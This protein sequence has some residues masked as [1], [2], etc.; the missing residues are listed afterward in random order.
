MAIDTTRQLIEQIRNAS[1]IGENTATRVGNA[2]NSILDDV[3]NANDVINKLAIDGKPLTL[4]S[5]IRDKYPRS[6]GVLT[7]LSTVHTYVYD[8]SGVEF[9]RLTWDAANTNVNYAVFFGND[10]TF[11]TVDSYI[12]PY[13]ITAGTTIIQ[14]PSGAAYVAF[15]LGS[16][17]QVDNSYNFDKV[18]DA[19][20]GIQDGFADYTQLTFLQTQ[21]GFLKNNGVLD[22]TSGTSWKVYLYSVSE[23]DKFYIQ[24]PNL[25]A[26]YAFYG[27]FSSS[28]LSGS[29]LMHVPSNDGLKHLVTVPPGAAVLVINAG[30]SPNWGTTAPKNIQMLGTPKMV[31]TEDVED[32]VSG[33]KNLPTAGTITD[34]MDSRIDKPTI[35]VYNYNRS[36]LLDKN[37]LIFADYPTQFYGLSSSPKGVTLNDIKSGDDFKSYGA[38]NFM[39]LDL[40]SQRSIFYIYKTCFADRPFATSGKMRISFNYKSLSGAKDF[41]VFL[42]VWGASP[43]N[44]ASG[45]IAAS[46]S[47]VGTFDYTFTVP[48]ANISSISY[49][50]VYLFKWGSPSAIDI[51]I[52]NL[53]ITDDIFDAAPVQRFSGDYLTAFMH[54]NNYIGK[55]CLYIGDSIS[56]ENNYGW[57]QMIETTYQLC[58]VR[59]MPGQLAPA[60]GGITVRPL[61]ADESSLANSAKSIWYR[62][63]GARMN[64][65]SFD[66]ISLFGGTND[67]N[68]YTT[69]GETTD[70]PYVDDASTFGTPAD[71]TDTWT[72]AL[73]FAQC[74]MGCVEMLRRDFPNNEIILATPYPMSY[75]TATD[76]DTN[77]PKSET[78]AQMIVKIG[79]KYGLKVVP[80]YW[81]IFTQSVCRAFTRD[82]VHPNDVLAR[83][84][85]IKYA[86]VL[87]Y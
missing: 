56:T 58:W 24:Q 63:A 79:Y 66:I 46:D 64:I 28:T 65:Y 12:K 48:T 15:S 72:N 85:A 76:P 42:Y 29:K 50:E 84:M 21:Y 20:N 10:A 13:T 7:N 33:N 22:G 38:L 70:K 59:G 6:T 75:G 80:L 61:Q 27:F 68:S 74:L 14:V 43:N 35:E 26:A 18:V 44:Y 54:P 32:F 8:L 19:V 31:V 60:N 23:G 1:Q 81:G 83:Q 34:Y 82:G 11:A 39:Q 2:M 73:T 67:L 41:K 86:Q 40:L 62:C 47:K 57:K 17:T 52:A 78:I 45:I 36:Y 30:E 25:G 16:L 5:I 4:N 87:G 77:L 69:I 71:Y 37:K 55:R 51:K 3:A 53:I 9:L 49:I